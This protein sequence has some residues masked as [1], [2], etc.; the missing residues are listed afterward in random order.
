MIRTCPQCACPLPSPPGAFAL[1]C[2]GLGAS[3]RA[4]SVHP[5]KSAFWQACPQCHAMLRRRTT[6]L[7][8]ALLVAAMVASFVTLF[9]FLSFFPRDSLETK[10][11]WIPG[12]LVFA[13]VLAGAWE[14]GYTWT[15]AKPG[16]HAKGMRTAKG[17][18]PIRDGIDRGFTMVYAVCLALAM[19]SL[20]A[21]FWNLPG[22]PVAF[23]G[24]GLLDH[25]HAVPYF[26]LFSG[27]VVLVFR[28]K[29]RYRALRGRNDPNP[30]EPPAWG[31][32]WVAILAGLS[33]LYAFTPLH[34]VLWFL[35]GSVGFAVVGAILLSI[36]RRRILRGWAITASDPEKR[37]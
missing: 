24:H 7:G 17:P 9:A 22:R 33:G 16:A 8:Y 4:P 36:R 37:S 13:L 20:A 28:Q 26:W 6:G 35:A 30:L 18:P 23:P 2:R 15:P 32:L 19:A 29:R 31:V 3:T 25:S 12:L 1:F 34:G 5:W 11:V 10:L 21:L 27:I 14:W